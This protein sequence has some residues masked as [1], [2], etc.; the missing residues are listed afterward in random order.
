MEN[1]L[2]STCKQ[3]LPVQTNG[4]TGYGRLPDGSLVCYHCIGI[5][6]GHALANAK[7]GEK[8]IY[9]LSSRDGVHEIS[10]WPGTF[11]QLVGH[12]V[13]GKHNMARVRYD[14][15]FRFSNRKFWGVQYGDNTQIAHIRC[16]EVI[17]EDVLPEQEI[18]I[19]L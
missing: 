4:G 10:N 8:F 1:F 15:W 3:T 17:G 13:K 5:Q 11:R 12:I 6:D 7:K 14:F 16:V 18:C 19:E 9:Y 2:C